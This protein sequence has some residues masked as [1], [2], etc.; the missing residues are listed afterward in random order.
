MYLLLAA[1]LSARIPPQKLLGTISAGTDA[2]ILMDPASYGK[3]PVPEF[4]VRGFVG[5]LNAPACW[6][7][8]LFLGLR[9]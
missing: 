9:S 8:F 4:L 5:G 1:R 3:L 6:F 7:W 2:R